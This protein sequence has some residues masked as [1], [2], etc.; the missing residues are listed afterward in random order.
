MLSQWLIEEIY[1]RLLNGYM[2]KN[3]SVHINGDAITGGAY[4]INPVHDNEPDYVSLQEYIKM[5]S[6]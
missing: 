4:N 5:Q 1:T 2:A 3:I 6:T